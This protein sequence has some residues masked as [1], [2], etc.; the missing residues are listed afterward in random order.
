M[1][2]SRRSGCVTTSMAT[3]SSIPALSTSPSTTA[4][5]LDSVAPNARRPKARP[6]TAS[7]T[8]ARTSGRECAIT[9]RAHDLLGSTPALA[10]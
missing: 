2:E 1:T 5:D 6:R 8:C 9:G 4:F 3:R 7:A 10:G